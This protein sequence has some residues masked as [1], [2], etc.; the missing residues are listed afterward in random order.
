MKAMA[1]LCPF[2]KRGSVVETTSDVTC[3]FLFSFSDKVMRLSMVT[4]IG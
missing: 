2:S 1:A 3:S 4:T